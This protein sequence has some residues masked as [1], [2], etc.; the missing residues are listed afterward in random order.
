M[1]RRQCSV[2]D[3]VAVDALPP[4]QLADTRGGNA[5]APQPRTDAKRDEVM[6]AAM[7]Q[8]FMGGAFEMVVVVVRDEDG[9]KRRQFGNGRR[10]R[11]EAAH[12][13]RGRR[14]VAAENGIGDKGL[15]ADTH[16]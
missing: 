2:A 5:P 10:R 8:L 11:L 3:A 4:V 15:P 14:D 1:A 7:R 12:G 9:I 16:Q 13:E 6:C